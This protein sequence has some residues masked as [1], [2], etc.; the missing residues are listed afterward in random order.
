MGQVPAKY[1][2]SLNIT[3]NV[4]SVDGRS[5][6]ETLRV[7]IYDDGEKTVF[8]KRSAHPVIKPDGSVEDRSPIS[9]S[10][11]DA[12]DLYP[13]MGYAEKFESSKV[14]TTFSGETIGV[15]ELRRYTIVT[16]LEGFQS[17]G[18]LPAPEGATIKLGVEIN[19]YEN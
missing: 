12:T 14:V 5:L 3:D 15:D 10:E 7:M 6:D 8:A 1:D 16:W 18:S 2:F 4:A 9:V 19:A 13:F 11:A 17:D